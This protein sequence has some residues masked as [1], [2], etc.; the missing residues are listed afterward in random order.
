M[1]ILI[2]KFLFF[3]TP[4][5]GAKKLIKNTYDLNKFKFKTRKINNIN[6][7]LFDYYG[8]DFFRR[9][10]IGQYMFCSM[11]V[12][13]TKNVSQE[14]EYYN[15]IYD[16]KTNK[17]TVI[18]KIYDCL[19]ENI[20]FKEFENFFKNKN[21]VKFIFNFIF[22][23]F[24]YQNENK[25]NET[26]GHEVYEII[27]IDDPRKKITKNE[28]QLELDKI[29]NMNNDDFLFYYLKNR[30][31]TLLWSTKFGANKTMI[32]KEIENNLNSQ[33]II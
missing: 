8:N 32:I 29:R 28:F 10:E 23:S 31:D 13:E 22:N 5:Y 6:D 27:V 17:I 11:V 2:E 4:H 18:Y 12:L 16:K 25:I 9:K 24:L 26:I 21:F 3:T 7:I 30:N 1:E 33:F 20:S 15:F 14:P 19:Y